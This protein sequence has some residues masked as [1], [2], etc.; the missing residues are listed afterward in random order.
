MA[1]SKLVKVI[2]TAYYDNRLVYPNEIIEFKGGKLPS[3]A[4]L[5]HGEKKDEIKN[6]APDDTDNVQ[7]GNKTDDEKKDEN[8]EVQ[9]TFENQDRV[10][11]L[12]KLIDESIEKGILI[13]N[14]ENKTVEEQIKELE[15][16]LNKEK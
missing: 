14:S 6:D 9:L 8:K 1:K 16:L 3:W 15:A 10:E 4:E 12:N 7:N 11:Y 2:K 5:I 13:D